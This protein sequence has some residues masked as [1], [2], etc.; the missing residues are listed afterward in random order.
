GSAEPLF[1]AGRPM[2]LTLTARND[3]AEALLALYGLPTLPIGMTGAGDTALSARGT[4][5]A[6]VST[7]LD[8]TSEGLSASYKGSFRLAEG[9][10][11]GEGEIALQSVDIEPWLMTTGL[12]MPGLGFG[13]PV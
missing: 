3:N 4:L 11:E 9:G 12:G 13:T 7:S 1:D 6:G 10:A 2:S 8:F 5:S